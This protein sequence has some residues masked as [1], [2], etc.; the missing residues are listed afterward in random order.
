MEKPVLS[1]LG[2]Q[3]MTLITGALI[4]AC[5]ADQY[6][7]CSSM[8]RVSE[9][10]RGGLLPWLANSGNPGLSSHAEGNPDTCHTD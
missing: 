9:S 6:R 1:S 8:G 3:W 10:P 4:S 7:S 5:S 2:L